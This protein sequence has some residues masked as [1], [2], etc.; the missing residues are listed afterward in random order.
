MKVLS[1]LES[2]RGL[3]SVFNVG[4]GFLFSLHP[5]FIPPS[6]PSPRDSDV[7][8]D[9]IVMDLQAQPRERLVS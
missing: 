2:V 1:H 6:R 8:L 5:P 9:H 3:H 7:G 4:F